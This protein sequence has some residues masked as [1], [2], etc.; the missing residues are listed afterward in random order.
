MQT[1]IKKIIPQMIIDSRG[2]PTIEVSLSLTDGTHVA[3]SVPSGASTGE[4]EALELRDN[5]K[6]WLGR[7]VNKAISNINKHI[8]PRLIGVEPYNINKIDQMMLKMDGTTNKTKLGANAILATSLAVLHAGAQSNKQQLFEYIH[9]QKNYTLP[10]PMM[11]ILNGGSH[12]DNNIDLQEFMIMPI[13]FANYADALRA[14]VEI[15]HNLKQILKNKNFNTSIGDE[16]GF[17]PNL[18]NNEEAIEFILQAIS[19]AGYVPGKE[20]F[21]ALDVAASEFYKKHNKTY[22]LKSEGKKLTAEDMVLYYKNLCKTYPII[23]I[24]DGLDQNDW[25]SWTKLTK[26]L[27]ASVQIVGDDLTVTKTIRLKKALKESCINAILIKLNQV[28][29]FTETM[30]TINLAKSNN[31]GIIIS[32]R[33]GETEDTTIA[34]LSVG[35]S[36][37]QIK[38]GSL[39]RTDRTAKY[40]QLLRIEKYLG[41]KAKYAKI[42]YLGC[43]KEEKKY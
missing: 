16:G 19:R 8:A 13:N 20:V 28:G 39:C 29:T 24:E 34:D 37:G 31:L 26:E 25:E 2:N 30:D 21:I 4:N 1:R 41:N 11:N 10:I 12:A 9:L 23:S 33:S 32:H 18:R 27:G 43:K 38:T 42:E 40:N 3:A 14:G 7:G 35:T 15:F 6:E 22:I 17:A 5:Q 36:A